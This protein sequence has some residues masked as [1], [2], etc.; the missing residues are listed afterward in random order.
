MTPKQIQAQVSR[1]WL[2]L[3][4]TCYSSIGSADIDRLLTEATEAERGHRRF[5][6]QSGYRVSVDTAAKLMALQQV[7]SQLNSRKMPN[8][9]ACY[10]ARKD[11][12]TAWGIAWALKRC[13]REGYS[14]PDL[15][16]ALSAIEGIDYAKDVA[17]HEP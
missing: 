15:K 16:G 4:T 12:V 10:G 2:A 8:V 5:M 17:P 9:L 7:L 6:R 14:M 13:R 11:C 3:E 1:A